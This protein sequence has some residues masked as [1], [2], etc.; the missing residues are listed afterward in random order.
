MEFQCGNDYC[1]HVQIKSPM[2]WIKIIANLTLDSGTEFHGS[3]K[4]MGMEVVLADCARENRHFRF[5]AAPK[6]PFG[7]VNVRIEADVD[8][9]GVV[10]GIANAPRH[11]PMEIKGE[12]AQ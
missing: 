7:V 8:D 5:T 10:T 2:G 1:F 6:L 11:R 4:L 12:L 3:A 9:D